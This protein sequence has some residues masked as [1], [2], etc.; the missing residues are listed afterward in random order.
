MGELLP[1]ELKSLCHQHLPE[2]SNF[3][4]DGKVCP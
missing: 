2:D 1:V 3:V 4:A